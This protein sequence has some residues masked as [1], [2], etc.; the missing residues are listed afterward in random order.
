MP[1]QIILPRQH[2]HNNDNNG[3]PGGESE[4]VVCER[5][6]PWVQLYWRACIAILAAY[7]LV[8]T[9]RLAANTV[10]LRVVRTL[11]SFPAGYAL[12]AKPRLRNPERFDHY[13]FG[14]DSEGKPAIVFDSPYAFVLHA[15]AL[16]CGELVGCGCKVCNREVKQREVRRFLL[17]EVAPGAHIPRVVWW[18]KIWEERW[19]VRALQAPPQAEFPEEFE[20]EVV[21]EANRLPEDEGGHGSDSENI[22]TD[23]VRYLDRLDHD[24]HPY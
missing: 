4:T 10:S 7:Y 1:S 14:F 13:L 24:D 23:P 16:M 9:G 17:R 18:R 19:T 3:N 6:K 20:E 21:L 8:F 12:F 2:T 11:R 22:H 15:A 5:S